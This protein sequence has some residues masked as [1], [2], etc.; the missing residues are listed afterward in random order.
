M[1]YHPGHAYYDA[2]PESQNPASYRM[3]GGLGRTGKEGERGER[4]KE[5]ERE[6][7]TTEATEPGAV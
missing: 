6:A 5:R 1:Y 4:E 7:V 3:D 2:N